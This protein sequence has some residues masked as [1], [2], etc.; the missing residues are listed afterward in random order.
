MLKL[1]PLFALSSILM[2]GVAFADGPV[3]HPGDAPVAF[4]VSCSLVNLS[5][6]TSQANEKKATIRSNKPAKFNFAK[7]VKGQA[8]IY[9]SKRGAAPELHITLEIPLFNTSASTS[10]ALSD[11]A[12]VEL[13]VGKFAYAMQ[14]GVMDESE[15]DSLER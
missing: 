1:K 13:K 12:R 14:C 10:S 3:P 7:A 4:D 2:S 15:S 8:A 11:D 6:V 9:P 5:G